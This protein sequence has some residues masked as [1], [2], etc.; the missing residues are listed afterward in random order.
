V[1]AEPMFDADLRAADLDLFA[2]PAVQRRGAQQVRRRPADAAVLQR[3][4]RIEVA[5]AGGDAAERDGGRLQLEVGLVEVKLG[6]DVRLPWAAAPCAHAEAEARPPF[7]HRLA[8]A[9]GAA[10]AAAARN[11]ALAEAALDPAA[12]AVR[13]GPAELGHAVPGV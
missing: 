9:G 3:D 4:G 6:V 2:D 12:L 5:D 10:P 13:S 7:H 11:R 1:V 8:E